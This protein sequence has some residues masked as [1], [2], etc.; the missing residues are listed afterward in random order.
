LTEGCINVHNNDGNKFIVKKRVDL[1]R[2]LHT[3]DWHLGK[4]LVTASRLPEQVEF[5]EEL[6]EIVEDQKV[7]LILIAGDIYDTN[8]PP[9]DAENLFYKTLIRLSD[10]GRRPIIIIAGNHDSPERISAAG[11]L[12]TITGVFI[13]GTQNTVVSKGSY[14]HFSVEDADEGVFELSIGGEKAVIIT[15][16]YPSEKRL[17]EVFVG[18]NKESELQKTYSEK[19]GA[20][21]TELSKK[22]R[23]DTINLAVGHFYFNGGISTD[24]ER[25]IQIGGSYAVDPVTLPEKA[26]YIAMGHLHRPQAVAGSTTAFYSGSPIQYSKSEINYAKSVHI[27]DI[28]AGSEAIIE[29]ILLRNYK[30]IEVWKADSIEDAIQICQDRQNENSWVFLEIKTDRP[31]LLSEI[32]EIKAAKKDIIEIRPYIESAETNSDNEEAKD[33]EEVKSLMEEFSVFYQ[34]KNSGAI[35][36][37]ELIEFFLS[38]CNEEEV[39]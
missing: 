5:I 3:S 36:D 23:D 24:S 39:S 11:P 17:N 4:Y 16:P 20:I 10:G 35:P 27:A 34:E 2:I 38:I 9:A 8:N 7:D 18:Q 37:R 30:P 22:Y 32:K 31:L 25:E 15:I 6:I 1:M 28:K 33:S 19:V 21:F 14:K 29:K 26:Q 13:I 12:A